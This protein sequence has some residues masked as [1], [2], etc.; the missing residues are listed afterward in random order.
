M[1]FKKPKFWDKKR[2]TIFSLIL[3]PLSLIVY[4]VAKLK[5]LKKGKKFKL[6]DVRNRS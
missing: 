5:R 3:F 2:Q 6:S 4:F 1:Q